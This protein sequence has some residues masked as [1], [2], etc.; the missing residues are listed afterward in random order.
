LFVVNFVLFLVKYVAVYGAFL[1]RVTL[2]NAAAV[3]PKG[4]FKVVFD[5]F[6]VNITFK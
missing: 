1:H 4:C 5:G 2:Q 6:S 3:K